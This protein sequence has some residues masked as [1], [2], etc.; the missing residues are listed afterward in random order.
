MTYRESKRHHRRLGRRF[1]GGPERIC[2][3][4]VDASG[5]R[6]KSCAFHVGFCEE[7]AHAKAYRHEFSADT[8]PKIAD[9]ASHDGLMRSFDTDTR[10]RYG[11]EGAACIAIGWYRYSDALQWH[12]GHRVWRRLKGK[13]RVMRY[14]TH[15]GKPVHDQAKFCAACGAPTESAPAAVPSALQRP[16]AV[17]RPS[18]AQRPAAAPSAMSG[19][20]P[21]AQDAATTKQKT[22]LYVAI[23]VV[24]T[25]ILVFAGLLI[26]SHAIA[27]SKDTAAE[28]RASAEAPW[29]E[30]NPDDEAD[31]S[32]EESSASKD[33]DEDAAES[34][35]T[36]KPTKRAKD[37]P[38]PKPTKQR[39]DGNNAAAKIR[40]TLQSGD[41]SV[42]AGRYCTNDGGCLIIDKTGRVQT[43]YEKRSLTL[44]EHDTTLH[45]TNEERYRIDPQAKDKVIMLS[46]PDEDYRCFST[47]GRIDLEGTDC[48]H[49]SEHYADRMFLPVWML[50]FPKGVELND[51]GVTNSDDAYELPSDFELANPSKPFI[52]WVVD[53]A[54]TPVADDLVYYL[55]D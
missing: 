25:L 7:N 22:I 54:S 6:L 26:Y 32:D 1:P 33:K 30:S 41:F 29:E 9:T 18:A 40:N 3:F 44:E 55:V 15:C 53:P 48:K 5:D 49:E 2:D 27:S 4:G 20:A 47:A 50:Y 52:Q 43:E 17:Q 12:E 23:A 36:S 8:H 11:D 39:D 28:T 46:G 13:R 38:S 14:C 51:S 10:F 42:I 37:K 24:A 19:N 31:S 21:A 16:S 45:V 34:T 35:A